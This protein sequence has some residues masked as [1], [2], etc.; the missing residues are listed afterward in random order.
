MA[1]ASARAFLLQR[2]QRLHHFCRQTLKLGGL[3]N[4]HDI[5][6]L[7]SQHGTAHISQI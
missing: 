7:A 3:P 5:G 6:V 4:P 2:L 1:Q